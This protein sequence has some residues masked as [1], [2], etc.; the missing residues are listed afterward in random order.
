MP[1]PIS[2]TRAQ[3]QTTYGS[4]T[5]I[6]NSSTQQ[7]N[8]QIPSQTSAPVKMTRAEY[9]T[10]FG[11]APNISTNNDT[12]NPK[13]NGSFVTNAIKGVGNLLFP[14]IGDIGADI[15]GKSDK[16]FLQ[17]TGDAALSALPF[18]PGLGEVGEGARAG[19]AAIE[20][21]EALAKGSDV[22]SKI[23]DAG[24]NIASKI[25]G[26]TVAKGA[27]TGYASGVA[28]NLSQGQGL[29]TA[30]DPNLNTVLGSVLGGALPAVMKG[31]GALRGEIANINPQVQ[32]ELE[33]MGSI[34][35]P[36][37]AALYDQY[38]NATKAHAT[39]FNKPSPLELAADQVDKAAQIVDKK[40]NLA[41][42][43]VG[44]A[45]E[46][47]AKIPL[48]PLND[49]GNSFWKD[50]QDKYG[51][52]LFNKKDGSIVAKKMAG[53]MIDNSPS[54]VSRITDIAQQLSDLSSKGGTAK[55]A[56]EVMGNI[57]KLIGDAKNEGYGERGTQFEGLMKHT[58]SNLNDVVRKSS[59]ELAKANDTFSGLKDLQDEISSMAGKKVDKGSLLMRRRFSGDK[60]G[61][62][63]DFFG[64]MRDATGIDLS[65]HAVLAKHAIESVGGNQDKTLLGQIM[66]EG[67]DA[68]TLGMKGL[69]LAKVATQKM[70][71]GESEGIGRNMIKGKT[72]ILGNLVKNKYGIPAKAGSEASRYL[73]SFLQQ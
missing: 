19:E 44:K 27:L 53:S 41:G 16:S 61:E 55:N 9:Q 36:K 68:K 59:P 21:G 7:T 24:A 48:G 6:P 20:G 63:S 3:Y 14:I 10:K 37:D 38:I 31:V 13:D 23:Y 8:T 46:A 12:Q 5:P 65:K 67:I 15:Q 30:F 69:N 4:P 58:A 49:V 43:M 66:N 70:G 32:T 33:K 60:A 22:A 18:I 2:M 51:L 42:A 11:Q 39:D 56:T 29:D 25:K 35:N 45:K 26:S 73:T 57:R 50:V 54:D 71:F 1:Q 52:N 17:Q 47:S 72:N 28:S 34:G 64:K 40:T 62:V